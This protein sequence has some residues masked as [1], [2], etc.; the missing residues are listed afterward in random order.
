VLNRVISIYCSSIKTLITGRCN[1]SK[2]PV[3]PQATIG[4]GGQAELKDRNPSDRAVVVAIP[5][6]PGPI[7]GLPF[8]EAEAKAIESLCLSIS[9][10]LEVSLPSSLYDKVLDKPRKYKVF[11]FA[12]HRVLHQLQPLKSHLLLK[13]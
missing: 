3:L 6:I 5:V 2:I 7:S 8:I 10:A 4:A 13:D 1:R 12:G 9:P 11:H